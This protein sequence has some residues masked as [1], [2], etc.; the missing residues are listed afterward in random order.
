MDE[1]KETRFPGA[2]RRRPGLGKGAE[3][4]DPRWR[5]RKR[6]EPK[7]VLPGE[8]IRRRVVEHVRLDLRLGDH[9][10][11]F[12]DL[13]HPLPDGWNP[14]GGGDPML[15]LFLL[16]RLLEDVP[17]RLDSGKPCASDF[18]WVEDLDRLLREHRRAID[19][20]LAAGRGPRPARPPGFICERL[21]WEPP[22]SS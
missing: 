15:T 2:A 22:E 10:V 17:E 12:L 8:E 5:T 1:G 13:L 6:F 3:P 21:G 20:L 4:P 18:P 9:V 19:D 14:I 16:R 11:E 7:L